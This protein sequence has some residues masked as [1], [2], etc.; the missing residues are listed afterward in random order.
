MGNIIS[1]NALGQH[2]PMS[3]GLTN[4][5]LSTLGLSG[6]HFAETEDEK[7]IIVWFLEKDQSV[8]GN[9]AVGFD[10]CEMPWRITDFERSKQFLLAT[11]EG[12]KKKIGWELLDYS[13]NEELLFPCLD[14]FR[15]MVS[16]MTSDML[17]RG[18]IK[19]WL[20]EP[21]TTSTSCRYPRCSKH[22][23]FLTDFGCHLCN[24]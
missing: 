16:Q 2:I 13:P 21:K 6:S 19:D 22:H 23:V 5:F 11:V 17:N 15:F 3:N 10:I 1:L 7:R 24:N 12:A 14:Q 9:G 18:A 4:V 8:L 20:D